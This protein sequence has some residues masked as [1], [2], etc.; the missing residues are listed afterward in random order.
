MIWLAW[1]QSRA[2]CLVLLAFLV[3]I[4]GGLLAIHLMLTALVATTGAGPCLHAAPS[5]WCESKAQAFLQRVPGF[6]LNPLWLNLLPPLAGLFVG[7]PTIAREM[8][9]G[10]FRLAWTQSGSRTRWFVAH[11]LV[12]LVLVTA[13]AA[14]VQAALFLVYQPVVGAEYSGGSAPLLQPVVFF[15]VFAVV[16]IAYTLFAVALGL[17]TGA[18][19]RRTVGAMVLVLVIF[20][21]VRI[22]VDTIRPHYMT[23]VTARDVSLETAPG[24]LDARFDGALILSMHQD[25]AKVDL[26][27]C[28]PGPVPGKGPICPPPPETIVYQP[29]TR[30][31]P[32]QLIESALYVVLSILLLAGSALLVRWRRA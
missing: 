12:A 15:D 20:A 25:Q 18:L 21:G 7:A 4:L 29:A 13:V 9:R 1:R 32:F 22:G 30:F 2:L 19:L 16:P 3:A 24:P 14:A 28:R 11:F 17:M 10:T 23:P 31:W 5:L 27:S 8:E 26:S 6:V